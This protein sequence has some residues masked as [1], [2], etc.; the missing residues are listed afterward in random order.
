VKVLAVGDALDA[1][2]RARR[3]VRR[4]RRDQLASPIDDGDVVE[5]RVQS[6]VERQ[7]PIACRRIV[8][9]GAER[10]REHLD[11]AGVDGDVLVNPVGR[12]RGELVEP[13]A[14]CLLL[15]VA[16][17]VACDRTEEQDGNHADHDEAAK[18][19]RT[20]VGGRWAGTLEEAY[21]DAREQVG[22][23]HRAHAVEQL[24]QRVGADRGVRGTERSREE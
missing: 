8:W 14:S 11:T 24:L 4:G 5:R 22:Q 9:Q 6:G 12:R 15:A 7:E 21:E 19:I 18:G 3:H 10:R 16:E 17:H 13:E 20:E 1:E 23:H 2:L